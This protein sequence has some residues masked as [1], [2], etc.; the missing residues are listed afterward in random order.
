[1]ISAII[2]IHAERQRVPETAQALLKINGVAEVYSVAGDYDLIAILRMRHFD[3][4]AQ[5]VTEK[6]AGI[7]TIVKTVTM[8]AFQ[9]YSNQDLERMWEIGMEEPAPAEDD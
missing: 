9:C 4:M 1:M 3:E 2:L 5:I 7:S 6:M 8:P